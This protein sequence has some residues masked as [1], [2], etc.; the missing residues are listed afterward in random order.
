ME[1]TITRRPATDADTE[2]AQKVHHT[3][4]HDVIVRQFGTFN[5]KMQDHFFFES[6]KPE[7]HEIIISDGKDA[8]FYSIVHLPDHIFVH[9][10]VLLPEFQGQGIGSRLLKE[11]LL[12]A[13]TKHLPV[14]LEVLKKNIAHNLYLR[15]GFKDTGENETHIQME[16]DPTGTQQK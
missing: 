15:F 16:I 5:E 14:R 12:E 1:P 6:W 10:L 11:V 8:G 7:T 13:K 4:Y 3:A 2:F 9:E